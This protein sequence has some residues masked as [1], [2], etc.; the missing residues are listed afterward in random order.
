MER[1]ISETPSADEPLLATT[2][3]SR[4]S[5]PFTADSYGGYSR[6]SIA[7]QGLAALVTALLAITFF[8]DAPIAHT[9]IG[10]VGTPVL[11]AVIA[12]RL[13]GGF[14]R[15]IDGSSV[16]GFA[17]RLS[18][19]VALVALGAMVASG[20]VMAASSDEVAILSIT[21]RP[22]PATAQMARAVHH[23]TAYVLGGTIGVMV[24]VAAYLAITGQRAALWRAIKPVKGGF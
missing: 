3:H 22:D 9:M 14:A 12:R 16:I 13:V 23:D 15:T 1:P 6:F 2:P 8:Y 24:V 17:G 11:L 10:L 21:A 20:L 7:L 19:I 18:V 4:L 5:G